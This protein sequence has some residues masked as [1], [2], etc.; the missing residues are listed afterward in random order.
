MT[1]KT[2]LA[3]AAVLMLGLASAAQAGSR[4]DADQPGDH[5][6]PLRQTLRGGEVFVPRPGSTIRTEGMCWE[7]TPQGNYAWGAC[8]Q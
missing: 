2:K 3:L 1:T 5:G 4:D 6:G 8:P 7:T